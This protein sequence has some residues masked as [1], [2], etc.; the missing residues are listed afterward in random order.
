MGDMENE[1]LVRRSRVLDSIHPGVMVVPGGL[2]SA[3]YGSSE[4]FRQ[5]SNFHYLTGFG[6]PDA[7][8]V[9][10]NLESRSVTLF[11]RDRDPEGERWDGERLGVERAAKV[12]QIDRAH[13]IGD[14]DRVLPDLLERCARLFY[15]L[16]RDRRMDD[17]VLG[18]IA[19]V[20]RRRGRVW[21]PTTI[22]ES[23]DILAPMRMVKSDGEIRLLE[24]AAVISAQVHLEV[25]A[26]ARAGMAEHELEATL[27]GGFRSR[28]AQ[29]P[30]YTPIVASGPNATVLHYVRNDR[31]IGPDDLVLV[32]AACEYEHYAADITRTFPVSG[33]FTAP[34]A[35]V[36]DVVLA[37][38]LAAIDAVR[39]GAT[40]E[41]VHQAAVRVLTT[42]LV[43]LGLVAGPVDEAIE[44]ERYKPF[45]MHRTSHHLGLDV[46]DLVRSHQF[47]EPRPLEVGNVVT[48]EPGIYVGPAEEIPE[49]YR[50]IGVRIE[51]DVVVT[52]DAP[53]VL[54]AGAPKRRED[55][56]R[57]CRG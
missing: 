51:D 26:G 5:D 38:Q 27:L 31:R 46:H 55:L 33:R 7:V 42:G 32:D 15:Q 16:G 53:R 17:R 14:L 9:L 49:E 48:V 52:G 54:T 41:D 29:R 45:F 34:Q 1:Y 57:A 25:M 36:Y 23:D 18:S 37:G 28:G 6:E 22:V 44:Q 4:R 24:R 11:L 40:L 3:A 2:G 13:P 39:A 10:S 21:W 30:A 50:G 12:M 20:R 19:D 56:E 8:L 43:D 35:A 47:G